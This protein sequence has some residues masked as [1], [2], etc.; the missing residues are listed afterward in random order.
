Q[1]AIQAAIGSKPFQPIIRLVAEHG[2][3]LLF[4]RGGG[5]AAFDLADAGTV[6]TSALHSVAP[7]VARDIPR[8]T[9]AILLSV[10]RRSFADTTLR[11][12]DHLRLLGIVLPLVAV[13]LFGLIIVAARDRRAAIA[14]SGVAIAITGV[15]LMIAYEL[16]RRYVVSHTYGTNE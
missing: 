1:S 3:R 4:E 7:K 5:N 16:M 12:A 2:H 15:A 6:V 9:D 13:A 11:V 14:R 10:R 8:R